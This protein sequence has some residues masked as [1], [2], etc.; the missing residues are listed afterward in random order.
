MVAFREKDQ[1]C[2]RFPGARFERISFLLTSLIAQYCTGR[3]L[4]NGS[5]QAIFLLHLFT[6]E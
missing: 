6:L 5:E 1:A 4:V 3:P 2:G